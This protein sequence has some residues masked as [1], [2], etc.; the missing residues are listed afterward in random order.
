MKITGSTL[1]KNRRAHFDYELSDLFEAGIALEGFEVKAA[2]A[3][4]MNLSGSYVLIKNKQPV[5]FNATIEPYQP[6]NTPEGYDSGR[7]RKLLL[8]KEEIKKL[9]GIIK[10]KR[11]SLIP[12]RVYKKGGLIKLEIK[13][14]RS[15]KKA[16]KRQSIKKRDTK[17]DMDREI[18]KHNN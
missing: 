8:K 11:I 13:V 15:K 17:R 2:R 18:K 4:K 1:A 5:L 7:T 3:G 14:G 6:A 9:I 16:D 12:I 10:E